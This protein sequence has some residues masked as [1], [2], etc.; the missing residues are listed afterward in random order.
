MSTVHLGDLLSALFGFSARQSRDRLLACDLAFGRLRIF[1]DIS[2]GGAR[3]LGLLVVMQWRERREGGVM[4]GPHPRA[5][6][7]VV[8]ELGGALGLLRR[9]LLPLVGGVT[10][11]LKTCRKVT[12]VDALEIFGHGV[13]VVAVHTDLLL[14]TM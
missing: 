7:A 12:V 2:R 14:G 4:T 9:L 3:P 10:L 1:D 11:R 5:V 13:L 8:D 6:Q